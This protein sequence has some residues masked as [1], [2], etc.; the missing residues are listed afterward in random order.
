MSYDVLDVRPMTK[1]IGAEIFGVD[2]S[3]P[4]TNKVTDE[5]HTALME[6]QVI[7]F[8]DQPMTYDS[9]KRAG[10][11]FGDLAM[12]SGVSGMPEHPEIVTIHADANS[13]FIAGEDWHS[14]LS[15]DPEPPMGSILY[16]HVVPPAG[17]DTLWSSM[18]AAYDALSPAMQAFLEPLTAVHDSNHIY[19]ALFPDVDKVYPRNTHPVVRTHPVTKRKCLFISKSKTV[20][21]NGLGEEEG[22]AILRFLTEHVKNPNFQ[23]RF[24]WQPN[25]V[26]FWDNRCTQHFATWDYFPETRSGY[27]VTIA[28][29]RPY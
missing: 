8:R 2:L 24:R 16:M 9:L 6:H 15:E 12:H 20:K 21:I 1:R 29:D 26:A 4:L 7:F 25:S 14:D 5:L 22:D 23:V 3:Q 10:R 11:S 13:K 18:Y 28:G 27:R 19:R 17:G